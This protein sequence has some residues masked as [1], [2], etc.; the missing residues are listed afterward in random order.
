VDEPA[1]AAV[2]FGPYFTGSPS[3]FTFQTSGSTGTTQQSVTLTGLIPGR[4]YSFIIISTDLYGNEFIS[5][6][7]TAFSFETE[8]YIQL[9]K[10]WN[11]ISIPPYLLDSTPQDVFTS[12]SGQFELVQAYYAS[13]PIDPWKQ[14][15]P[16]KSF[17]NDLTMISA[18]DG[19]WILM[20]EDAVLIPDHKDPLT[21]PIFNVTFIGLEIGWNLVSYPSVQTRSVNDALAG[22]PFD[23]IQTYDAESGQWLTHNGTSGSLTQMEMGRGYWIHCTSPYDWKLAYDE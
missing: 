12:I 16:G 19:L 1:D 11:M 9:Y 21:D 6:Y 13:D 4:Y 7:D 18:V 2:R 17:G 10:G 5:S 20:K 23:M 14:F 15:S 8:V 3:D 22:V